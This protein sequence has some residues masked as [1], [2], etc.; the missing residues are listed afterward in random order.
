MR[1]HISDKLGVIILHER[2]RDQ[3]SSGREVHDS[4]QNR[5]RT[6]IGAATTAILDGPVDCIG[7]IGDPI[8]CGLER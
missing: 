6:T 1:S 2:F 7:I 4:G 8:S 3:I 5:G